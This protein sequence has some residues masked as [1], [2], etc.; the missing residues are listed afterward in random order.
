MSGCE[1]LI[2]SFLNGVEVEYPIHNDGSWRWESTDVPRL[3]VKPHGRGVPRHEIPIANVRSVFLVPANIQAQPRVEGWHCER[4]GIPLEV[5]SDDGPIPHEVDS[6][7]A[8]C[9]LHAPANAG[10][11]F[12]GRIP[13]ADFIAES[14]A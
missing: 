4:C 6:P 5:C 2:V 14:K 7:P 11:Y 8:Y 10:F 1:A 3:V 12:L 13:V 9:A